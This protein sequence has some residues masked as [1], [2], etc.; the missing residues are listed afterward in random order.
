M[1]MA[2]GFG[3][4]MMP[5]TKDMAKPMIKVE[6][7]SLIE[8]IMHKLQEVGVKKLV[9]NLHHH[10]ELLKEFVLN[11][12]VSKSF[13]IIFSYEESPL[14][15]GGI[16]KA[17]PYFDD[18]PFFIVNSDIIWLEKED[19]LLQRMLNYWDSSKMDCLLSLQKLDEILGHD[20]GGDFNL[21]KDD[22]I[23]I[24]QQSNQYVFSGIRIVTKKLFYGKDVTKFNFFKDMLFKN[25]LINDDVV[26]RVYGLVHNGL[27]FDIGNL[28][29]LKI[30]QSRLKDMKLIGY[31]DEKN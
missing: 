14:E 25:R 27:C 4:R 31:L 2:A 1:I 10:G 24:N 29:G 7:V 17:L 16:V 3:S 18:S 15:A 21:S 23:V 9:I 26:D 30:A 5:I 8:F 11:L 28:E 13:E 22:K 20:G 6:G 19:K 12:E